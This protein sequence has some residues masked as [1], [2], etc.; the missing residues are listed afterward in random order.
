MC[1]ARFLYK[2]IRKSKLNLGGFYMKKQEYKKQEYIED[3]RLE[4]MSAREIEMA[5]KILGYYVSSWRDKDARGLFDLWEKIESYWEGEAHVKQSADDPCS[6]TNIIHPNIEGQ[7]ALIMQE[8][9]DVSAGGVTPS[10]APYA[11]AA[12]IAL[13]WC[14][15]KNKMKRKIDLHERRREKFGTGIFRVLFDPDA[16]GGYGLPTI[17]SVNPS[18]V[19][20]DPSISDIYKIQE[21]A[22]I[23]EVLN[24]PISWAKEVFGETK[25]N[26]IRAG[27]DP[28]HT[29]VF[30]SSENN[31]YIHIMAWLRENGKLRLVQMSGCGV[32][33]WDSFK[34][35]SGE[36]FYPDGRFP[37]F[38]TP[39]YVREGSIW[40]KGDAELLIPLQDLIDELDDQIRI[41]A[42]LSGNP[43]RLVDIAT[44]ID[45]DKWTNE[46]GLIIPTTDVSGVKYLEPPEMPSYPMERRELALNTERQLLTRFSDQMTGNKVEGNTT[47]TEISAMVAQG[48]TVISHKKALLSETLCEI[49]EY[50]LKLMKEYY[51]STRAFG[52]NSG[53]YKFL[54]LSELKS[55]PELQEV[56]G[57]M[58]N[59]GDRRK[60]AE[61][62]IKIKIGGKA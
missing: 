26:L 5:D 30:E 44:N 27:Y 23:I 20:C 51:T 54:T 4:V 56:E 53:D 7:V 17:E 14:L 58:V 42:R 28:T 60:D 8:E 2:K 24:K 1:G 22:F 35:L 9:L 21:G 57:E 32:I 10:D 37:Y 46:A 31:S 3:E 6:N 55:I 43:Q 45:L 13:Q 33:L 18:Y 61:F 62:D 41:N 29:R 34:E 50:C 49:C 39:L 15:D 59:I 19:F 16:A 12:T 11:E 47:A 25:A 38:F 52:T 40:A 36:S 48:N